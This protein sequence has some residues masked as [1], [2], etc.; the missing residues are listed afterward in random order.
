M[1]DMTEEILV[2]IVEDFL[3]DPE[4]INE[5]PHE[6]ARRIVSYILREVNGDFRAD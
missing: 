6:I 3:T 5:T 4:F 1:P 2:N